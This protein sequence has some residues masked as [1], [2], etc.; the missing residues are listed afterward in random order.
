MAMTSSLPSPSSSGS[1]SNAV[2][3]PSLLS[4]SETD[5]DTLR[6]ALAAWGFK[7]QA[8]KTLEECSELSTALL[9]YDSGRVT[10]AEVVSEIADVIIM[11]WQIALFFGLDEVEEAV[12][13]K[14]D[15]V[16]NLLSAS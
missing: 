3:A 15:R 9:K 4:G 6:K 2:T 8:L 12:Q 7:A 5:W 13:Y 16:R 14:L 10:E 1:L 11:S